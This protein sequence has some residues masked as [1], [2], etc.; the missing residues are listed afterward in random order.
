VPPVPFVEGTL[1]PAADEHDTDEESRRQRP[2]E[3]PE[4]LLVRRRLGVAT[5]IHHPFRRA[6][7]AGIIGAVDELPIGVA[8]ELRA[9]A[10]G[11]GGVVC[12]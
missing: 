9:R 1:S 2:P 12:G 6:M 10:S 7:P 8:S 5:S 3:Q 11:W 4:R